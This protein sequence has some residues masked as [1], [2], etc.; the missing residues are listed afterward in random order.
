MPKEVR[1]GLKAGLSQFISTTYGKR[2]MWAASLAAE[3]RT[4]RSNRIMS[5]QLVQKVAS[6]M[7]IFRSL[8][9]P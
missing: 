2:D 5:G 7:D 9:H 8:D 3:S 4:L 1:E 6:K